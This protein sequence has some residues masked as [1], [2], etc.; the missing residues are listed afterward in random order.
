QHVYITGGSQG[1]G[2][3]LAK[4]LAS[5]G[6]NVTIVARTVSKLEAA[7]KEIEAARAD[8]AQKVIFISADLGDE[9]A[10]V[11][12]L[13][14]AERRM[15]S[16]VQYVFMVAGSSR[17]AMFSQTTTAA[18]A[19][20][21]RTDYLT[22]AFTAHAAVQ[23]FLNRNENPHMCR[24]VFV[25]SLV[26]L[27]GLPG[28]SSYSAAKFALRGLAECLRQEMLMYG[29]KVHVFYPGTIFSPGYEEEQKVKP[30][31]TK[32][33][34][35][36]D[37]GVTCEKAAEILVRGIKKEKFGI[38]CDFKGELIRSI[39]NGIPPTNSFF[40]DRVLAAIAWIALPIWRKGVDNNI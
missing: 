34:E 33:I 24:L 16:S 21:M 10:C 11:E 30:N 22:A 7:V 14:E 2:L 4:L 39:N 18:I 25:S 27:M 9:K 3:A 31:L 32:S 1:T 15:G 5:K 13:V 29:V 36:G 37:G 6:A 40:G 35:E 20:E 28:Y 19:H 8:V 26:G 23:S 38:T 12:A 17:P